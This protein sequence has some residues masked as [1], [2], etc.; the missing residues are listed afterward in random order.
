MKAYKRI[1]KLC[2]KPFEVDG[3][4]RAGYCSD[5]CRE[6][7]NR[8]R[9][10][11]AARNNRGTERVRK[12]LVEKRPPLPTCTIMITDVVPVFPSMQPPVGSVHE[13]EYA[14]VSKRSGEKVYIIPDIGSVG[15]IIRQDEC[16]EI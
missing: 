9:C 12:D 2:G 16:V 14:V 4:S 15:L 8:I 6:E 11:D 13:A 10:R 3:K 5:F 7:R 1:C